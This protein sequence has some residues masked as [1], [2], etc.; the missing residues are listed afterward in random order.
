[1]SSPSTPV[2]QSPELALKINYSP[3]I[4][5]RSGPAADSLR[6]PTNSAESQIASASGSSLDSGRAITWTKLNRN[7]H[8]SRHIYDTFPFSLWVEEDHN[9][10]SATTEEVH[11]ILETYKAKGLSIKPPFIV[12]ITDTPP[13]QVPLTIACAPAYFVSPETNASGWMPGI[14]F[15]HSGYV[16]TRGTNPF[17][18][19]IRQRWQPPSASDVEIIANRLLDLCNVESLVFSYPYLTVVIRNDGRSY[20]KRSLPGRVGFW[21]TTYYHGEAG[22]WKQWPLSREHRNREMIPDCNA[23][24]EDT[25]NYLISGGFLSPG[26]RLAGLEQ[27]TSCG[28]RVKNN[29]SG[30][31]RITCANHGFLANDDVY[32]PDEIGTLIGQIKE[33]YKDIALFELVATVPFKNDSYFEAPVPKRLLTEAELRELNGAWFQADG[34]STGVVAFMNSGITYHVPPRRP[35]DSQQIPYCLFTEEI[36]WSTVGTVGNEQLA[37]GICGA[38][39]VQCDNDSEEA[40]ASLG[41][42]IAGFFQ[43]SYGGGLSATPVLDKLIIDGWELY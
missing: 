20:E 25:S 36:V 28:V 29:N 17:P 5:F 35:G 3:F 31:I 1:M 38:P 6:F 33:R 41:G 15:G 18:E 23:G 10:R 21:A 19:C 27:S 9:Y 16:N 11:L 22:L 43:L 12:V 39:L 34:M 4:N 30:A 2:R 32:H 42:G 40:D 14:P 26:V 13:K 37:D 7:G 8:G 24:I